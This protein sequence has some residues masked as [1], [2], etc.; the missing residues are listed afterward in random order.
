VK[1]FEC[2][3]TMTGDPLLIRPLV[4]SVGW[5]FSC[6][7]DDPQMGPGVFCYATQYFDSVDSAISE[8]LA[9]GETLADRGALVTRTKVEEIRYD[10][11]H[12]GSIPKDGDRAW[13][14]RLGDSVVTVTFRKKDGTV[15]V[16]RGTT[17]L[18]R[19]PVEHHPT[20]TGTGPTKGDLIRVYDLDAGGW[21]SL[22]GSTVT[23]AE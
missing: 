7:Q 11:R 3:I 14:D 13:K 15:R 4:E 6:I 9:T 10:S 16:L 17:D 23:K 18:A 1:K 19:I 21:R 8:T 12:G 22:Y 5:S 20:G 2:H